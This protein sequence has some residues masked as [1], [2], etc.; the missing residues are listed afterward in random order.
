M[1]RLLI[2]DLYNYLVKITNILKAKNNDELAQ[3]VV[4]TSRFISSATTSEFLEESLSMLK[5]LVTDYYNMF[6]KEEQREMQD[7]ISRIKY[8]FSLVNQRCK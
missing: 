8:E 4:W 6:T 2:N 3:Q 7:V 1:E 5:L